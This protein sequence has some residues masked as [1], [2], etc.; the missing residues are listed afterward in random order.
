[1]KKKL[2]V[3]ALILAMLFTML[4]FTA[5]GGGDDGASG[6]AATTEASEDY[7]EGFVFTQGFD[8][9]YPP[10][11]YRDDSGNIGGFD[12]EVAQALCEELGWQYE[13]L[14]FNWDAKD[15]ELN[16]GSCDCIWSGLTV[17][18][19][20]DDYLFSTV[21]SNNTQMIMVPNDSDIKTLDDLAG[22]KVGVQTAT[23]AYDM[24]NDG[25]AA[26]LAATFGDLVVEETYTICFNDLQAGAIDAIAID[27]TTGDYLM[28]TAEGYGYL[29]EEL[30][31]ETYAIAFRKGDEALR[32]KVNEGLQTLVDNG[33]FY[34]IAENYPEIKDYLCLGK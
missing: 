13:A 22:K 18:G 12:V 15:A 5:C 26:D 10:Y 34:E 7:G 6:E 1:M 14:P 24:L 29:D 31:S 28:S 19:R 30:G 27:V 17:E 20:E 9:D 21:Y 2:S 23:S 4:A 8:L 3:L 32:D 16:S 25:D 11:S 33:K